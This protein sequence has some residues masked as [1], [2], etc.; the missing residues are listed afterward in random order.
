MRQIAGVIALLLLTTAA[1]AD[2]AEY[3]FSWAHPQPQGNS[4]NGAAFEDGSTGYAVGDRGALVRTTDGGLSWAL[5]ELFPSFSADLEDIVVLGPGNLLAVGAPPGIFHSI[6]AGATWQPVPNPSFAR[7][8]DIEQVAP[9]ALCA[10]GEDGQV[11]RSTD[12]GATWSLL[13][14]P[15]GNLNEQLWFDASNAYVVGAFRARRTT[16]GGQTW[17]PLSGVPDHENFTE[18]FFTDAQHGYV[19]SDFKVWKTTNAGTSWTSTQ[20]PGSVVYFGNAIALGPEHFLVVS[21]IEGASI[22]ET[23]DAGATWSFAL[24]SG[25]D[26]FRDFDRLTDGTLLAISTEGDVF[27]STDDGATWA[28]TIEAAQPPRYTIGAIAVSPSGKGAAGTTGTPGL[29]WY[30]SSD[31]GSNWAIRPSGPAIAFAQDIAWWDGDRA[32]VAGD[33]G[34]MWR[35]TD[36]GASWTAALLPSP[37]TNARAWDLALP[38]SG[39]AFAAVTGQTQAF[40]YRTT[41]FGASWE[42]RSTGIPSAGGLTSVSFPTPDIGFACGHSGGTARMYKTTDSGGSWSAMTTAGLANFPSDMHWHDASTGLASVYLNPGGIYRTTDG[43]ASWQSVWNRP[44]Y[45]LAFSDPLHGAADLAQFWPDGFIYVTEDGGASWD[46]LMLPSTEAGS[47]IAAAPNGFW[48]AGSAGVIMRA[49]R[50]SPTG[51]GDVGIDAPGDV[52]NRSAFP[53]PASV[54]RAR[55]AIGPRLEVAFELAAPG[56]AELAIFDPA[57]RRVALLTRG[58]FPANVVIPVAW[59]GARDDGGS[60]AGGIYFARLVSGGEAQA[61]K[62]T[63]IR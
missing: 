25:S 13:P 53:Q 28:N 30:R 31:D 18:A 1:V 62:L 29:Q 26:G 3:V 57:G 61:V 48:L 10:V 16:D 60:A 7:L 52:S 32:V 42:Q 39:T 55:A 23:T 19:L 9:G 49:T 36:G 2:A 54:L 40:V 44:S 47:A 6:D 63:L 17:V 14:S 5:V 8:I 22:Y 34:K 58:A 15:G 24:N 59:D 46:S 37:P 35:T 20:P 43:G 45:D 4:L 12:S 27:R 51:V 11:L 56:T 33:Y 21:T 50:L 38:A 41:D